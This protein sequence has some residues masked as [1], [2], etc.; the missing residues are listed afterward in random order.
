MSKLF[1][2][3]MRAA[4]RISIRFGTQTAS[5]IHVCSKMMCEPRSTRAKTNPI[6]NDC[7]TWPSTFIQPK[8]CLST[9]SLPST[10]ENIA[11]LAVRVIARV[12]RG[13]KHVGRPASYDLFADEM[14]IEGLEQVL[15]ERPV[16]LDLAEPDSLLLRRFMLQFL[17]ILVAFL[18]FGG[19]WKL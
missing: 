7:V 3:R 1:R 16:F 14:E 4:A 5:P 19:R 13:L 15:K 8:S 2:N 12:R 17:E 18:L 11:V 6:E 10:L 9:Q